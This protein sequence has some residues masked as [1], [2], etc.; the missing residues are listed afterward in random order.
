METGVAAPTG[1]DWWAKFDRILGSVNKL[2][3][4]NDRVFVQE[5]SV[6]TEY[7]VWTPAPPTGDTA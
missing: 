3:I 2:N 5:L 7:E 1:D 4:R 6:G